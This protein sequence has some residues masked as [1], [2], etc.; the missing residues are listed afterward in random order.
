MQPDVRWLGRA[1]LLEI[2]F[3]CRSGRSRNVDFVYTKEVADFMQTWCRLEMQCH[4]SSAGIPSKRRATVTARTIF[5]RHCSHSGIFTA[6]WGGPYS[7]DLEWA[8]EGKWMGF[9]GS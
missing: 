5:M 1:D 2:H 6:L 9:V 7:A 8:S 3:A 4:P